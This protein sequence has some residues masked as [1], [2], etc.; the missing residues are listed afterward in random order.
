MTRHIT[1]RDMAKRVLVTGGTGFLGRACLP[2]LRAA[3]FEVHAVTRGNVPSEFPDLH[4]HQGDLFNAADMTR[5]MAAVRPLQ[6]LHFAWITTPG[7]YWNSPENRD[8]LQASLHLAN[9]FATSGGRRLVVAGSCAEYMQDHVECDES[10]QRLNPHTLYGRCKHELHQ[11]LMS[12]SSERNLSLGWGRVFYP[13]GP[14]QEPSRLV[15]SIIRSLEQGNDVSLKTPHDV[16]DFIHVEDVASAFVDLLQ[17][18]VEGTCNIA[19]G[20]GHTIESVARTIGKLMGRDN[21]IATASTQTYANDACR[22]WVGQPDRLR[23]ATGWRPVLSLNAG[24]AHTI[25]RIACPEVVSP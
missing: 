4:W 20:E 19:T 14:E 16:C 15:P 9:S 2:R 22:S 13:Y 3:G 11:R 7:E 17:S 1:P 12:L 10:M 21:V 8:W 6:C 18:H 5:L 25:S 24:L 23:R